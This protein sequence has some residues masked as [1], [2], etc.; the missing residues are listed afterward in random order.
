MSSINEEPIVYSGFQTAIFYELNAYGRPA[1]ANLDAYTG[2]EV[3]AAKLYTLTLPATRKISHIGNDRLLKVQQFPPQEA[4]TGEISVGAE[5]LELIAALSGSTVLEIAGMQMLPHLSDLQGSEPNVGVI[6]YQAALA[7]SGP[8]RFHFHMITSTKA[9]VRLPG[10]GA[11]PIDLIYDIAPDPVDKYLWGAD[12]APLDDPSDP[13]SGI[14]AT[15]AVSAGVHS[16][17]SAYEPRIASFVA[18]GTQTE[19]LYPEDKQSADAT[20]I[21]VFTATGVTVTTVAGAD[22]TSALTGVTF[23]VAPTSGHEVHLLYQKASS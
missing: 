17:F 6:L 14:P 7:Q 13:Y 9:I 2:I 3:Y 19:F 12:L 20:N 22:Y 11:E 10:F 15:G 4:A 1:A 5:D 8:Q 21:A 23:S 16:G 18:D